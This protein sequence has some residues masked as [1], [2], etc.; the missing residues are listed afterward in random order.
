MWRRSPMPRCEL[1]PVGASDRLGSRVR[2]AACGLDLDIAPRQGRGNAPSALRAAPWRYQ[3]SSP[4][5]WSIDDYYG[6]ALA[7]SLRL[8]A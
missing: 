5:L 4:G 1:G 8:S 2:A 3:I 7:S 6:Q